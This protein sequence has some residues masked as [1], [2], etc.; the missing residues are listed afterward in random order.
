[1]TGIEIGALTIMYLIW[2]WRHK[3]RL[4]E[5]VGA[6]V[7]GRLPLRE[8]VELVA[9][10]LDDE[11][12]TRIQD[13]AWSESDDSGARERARSAIERACARDP[14]FAAAL[15]DILGRA[16]QVAKQRGDLPPP[17][18]VT[19]TVTASGP[20]SVA[21]VTVGDV[22]IGDITIGMPSDPR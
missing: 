8:L 3:A 4:S 5:G 6:L 16:E 18:T 14:N 19:N 7:T 20:G 22:T 13:E 17:G 1:M 2:M 9:G 12:L 15:R 10:E 21:G 11:D